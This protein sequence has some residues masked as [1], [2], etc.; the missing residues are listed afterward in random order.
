MVW[1]RTAACG[2]VSESHSFKKKKAY[3]SILLCLREL[4]IYSATKPFK[5][6]IVLKYC[7]MQEQ[8]GLSK[9]DRDKNAEFNGLCLTVFRLLGPEATYVSRRL[10]DRTVRVRRKKKEKNGNRSST[11]F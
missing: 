1:D 6:F 11:S 4:D 5:F 8:G 3:V 7:S 9:R 2:I 10:R